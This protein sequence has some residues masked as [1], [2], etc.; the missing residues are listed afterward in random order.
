MISYSIVA[1]ACFASANIGALFLAALIYAARRDREDEPNRWHKA[2]QREANL[3]SQMAVVVEDM[4]D[5]LD[6]IAALETAKCASV[7]RR[8][9]AIARGGL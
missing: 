3:N 4:T 2:W 5:R 7:G 8:M 9:S 1:V 6:R